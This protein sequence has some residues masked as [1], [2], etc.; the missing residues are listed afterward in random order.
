MGYM[1]H[2]PSG[3][4]PALTSPAATRLD[5]R[6]KEA[7]KKTGSGIILPGYYPLGKSRTNV[8]TAVQKKCPRCEEAKEEVVGMKA[9]VTERALVLCRNLFPTIRVSS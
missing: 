8:R 2:T 6:H 1:L 7:G 9:K 5:L 4:C 3:F